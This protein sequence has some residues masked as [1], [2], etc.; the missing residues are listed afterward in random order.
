MVSASPIW[1]KIGDFG[2][3]KLARDGTAF[4]TPVFTTGYFAPE[5]GIAT[6]GDSSEYTN[7]VDIWA[8]GCIAHEMLTRTLPFRNFYQLSLYCTRPEF[9]RN[10][11][12]QKNI[13]RNG[14]E[15]VESMLA[16]SP[17][18]RISAKEALD[19][20]W[21][22]LGD[23]T[24]EGLET[25]EDEGQEWWEAEEDLE[26]PALPEVV[27]ASG[28]AVASTSRQGALANPKPHLNIHRSVKQLLQ[29]VLE[30][31]QRST[32][33]PHKP[34]LSDEG[35]VHKL[36][37]GV[38]SMDIRDCSG[39]TPLHIA[40]VICRFDR[41]DR[42][43]PGPLRE[44]VASGADINTKNSQGETPLFRAV[45][46]GSSVVV[47]ELLELGANAEEPN[48]D[49][50]RPLMR[51]VEVQSRT[52]VA[53]LLD[54]GALPNHQGEAETSTPLHTAALLPSNTIC[55]L[56]LRNGANVN[57]RDSLGQTPLH[58]AVMMRR[59]EVARSLI[60][61][62]ACVE[63]RDAEQKTPLFRA[64]SVNSVPL[65]KLLLDHGA[66]P[67]VVQEKGFSPRRLATGEGSA[68]E[69]V[70]LFDRPP[71]IR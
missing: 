8:V 63:A 28:A 2:L 42:I 24:Q 55:Q 69:M 68:P 39:N 18:G 45:G 27:A 61:A 41:D 7:A 17:E 67:D 56:I 25:D 48:L 3:A 6:G 50:I 13:S 32:D 22:R 65:A 70:A 23:E 31:I 57:A 49:G 1:V 9:P 59:V 60:S 19:S 36:L 14:M 21:L 37:S 47:K 34:M 43:V 12:L 4:R 38:I 29:S 53:L 46:Y 33:S 11:M 64:V 5:A 16:L 20:E 58:R 44:L 35:A 51:A 52:L 26:G 71:V 62:G 54:H 10:S 15:I 66:N 40:V 30:R